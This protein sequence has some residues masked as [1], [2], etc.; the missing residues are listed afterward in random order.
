LKRETGEITLGSWAVK[1]QSGPYPY[2]G[3]GGVLISLSL[4]VEPIG[5]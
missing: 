3:I 4:A 2:W 1:K 5:G